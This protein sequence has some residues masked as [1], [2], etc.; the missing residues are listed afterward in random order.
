[1]RRGATVLSLL[2]GGL[3]V[4]G[5][6]SPALAAERNAWTQFVVAGGPIGWL[7]IGLDVASWGLILEYLL[8]IRRTK[9]LPEP[10]RVRIAGLLAK[11]QYREVIEYTAADGSF[12][13]QVVH[14]GLAE[15]NHGLAA[16]E[17]AM[18]EACEVRTSG[19]LRKV[20]LLNVIGNV[21]PMLGLLGTVYGMIVTFNRIVQAGGLPDPALL[22]DG[23]GIAL[24]TTFW[25]LVVAVPALAVYAF[26]RNR[27]DGVSAEVA[28]AAGELLNSVRP[29]SRP[30]DR[31]VP[32]QA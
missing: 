2:A 6:S 4:L 27:I 5:L 9:M 14:A 18:A 28:L 3:V 19:L 20:E 25:G 17:R 32:A 23:I 15:A 12:L 21:A 7:L 30:E 1:M 29:A 26:M 31:P 10:T 16:M 8:R 13:A 22:A 11:R 24:V